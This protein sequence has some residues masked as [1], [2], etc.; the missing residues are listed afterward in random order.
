MPAQQSKELGEEA[1]RIAV[2]GSL[3]SW[4]RIKDQGTADLCQVRRSEQGR[5]TEG[6]G[7][8]HGC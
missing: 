1:T 3:Q 8:G 6:D 2:R 5:G 7:R 4:P